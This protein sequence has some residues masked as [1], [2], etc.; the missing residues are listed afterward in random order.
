MSASSTLSRTSNPHTC[1]AT[2]CPV[3]VPRRMFM[4]G[5][6]WRMLPSYLQN[7]IWKEYRKGQEDNWDLVTPAY[8]AVTREAIEMIER[9][10]RK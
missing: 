9:L 7:L 8:L 5:R 4:C 3:R 2:G 6:H 1:H 10:E